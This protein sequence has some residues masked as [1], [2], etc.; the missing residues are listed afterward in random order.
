MTPVSDPEAS[1]Y[2]KQL[3]RY[4]VCMAFM[5]EAEDWMSR[6]THI[7]LQELGADVF[8]K[9]KLEGVLGDPLKLDQ[10]VD[11]GTSK[12]LAKAEERNAYFKAALQAA[13]DY[14][15]SPSEHNL[16]LLEQFIAAIKQ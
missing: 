5:R 7:E 16:K 2:V 11:E 4:Y 1:N 8:N 13:F 14:D 15:H 6:Q 12:V 10:L 9:I 3:N